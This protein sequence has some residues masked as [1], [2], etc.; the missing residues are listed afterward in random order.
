MRAGIGHRVRPPRQEFLPHS[1]AVRKCT[2]DLILKSTTRILLQK[3]QVPGNRKDRPRLESTMPPREGL[4]RCN[5]CG[6]EMVT[7]N[8]SHHV[9]I[10]GTKSYCGYFRLIDQPSR[11]V[12]GGVRGESHG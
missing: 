11:T 12:R 1:G 2:Y 3:F 4:R 5:G 7:S 6:L 8:G 10:G 9:R